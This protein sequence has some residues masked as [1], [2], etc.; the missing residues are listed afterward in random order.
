M[1]KTIM[2]AV[3]IIM[4]T[5][6]AHATLPTEIARLQGRMGVFTSIFNG[7]TDASESGTDCKIEESHY[8]EGS[9]EINSAA[10]FTPTAHLDGAQKTKEKGVTKFITTSSGKRPGGSVCGDYIPL[11]S[12]K[13]TVTVTA[14]ALSINEK[15]TCGFFDKNESIQTCA[16]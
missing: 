4:I 11:T 1:K 6:E 3:T 16:L 8:G 10:Y 5:V 15:Y 14:N 13:Q 2:L 7:K 9:V 12:Y